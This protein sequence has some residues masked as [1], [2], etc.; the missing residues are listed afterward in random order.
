MKKFFVFAA[1]FALA[2]IGLVFVGCNN[3]GGSGP[4]PIN[5][6]GTGYTLTLTPTSARVV[7]A[8]NYDYILIQTATSKKSS[9]TAV[10]GNDGACT[11]TPSNGGTFTA[12][13]SGSAL[14]ISGQPVK[15]D[16]NTTESV[17]VYMTQSNNGGG[18]GGGSVGNITSSGSLTITGITATGQYGRVFILTSPGS[19]ST[20][21]RGSGTINSGVLTVNLKT[22]DGNNNTWTSTGDFYI[23]LGVGNTET[24]SVGY[25]ILNKVTFVATGGTDSIAFNKFSS[26]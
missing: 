12:T 17:T 8:G 25:S 11:F 1:L 3:G 7:A 4:T 16:D 19:G 5:Y 24:P 26:L 9:G 13:L 2:T 6:S 15:F 20:V 10:V 21:A 22:T 18:G 23:A 14:S